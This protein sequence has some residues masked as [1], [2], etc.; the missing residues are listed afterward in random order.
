MNLTYGGWLQNPAPPKGWL[1]PYKQWD[2]YHRPRLVQDF[3]TIHS[4]YG[5]ITTFSEWCI[6]TQ[7][8]VQSYF[9]LPEST[10]QYPTPVTL[11]RKW[12]KALDLGCTI[13]SETHKSAIFI[14]FHEVVVWIGPLESFSK[15]SFERLCSL[16]WHLQCSNFANEPHH[17]CWACCFVRY[18]EDSCHTYYRLKSHFE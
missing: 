12:T 7:A 13:F 11:K 2:V 3:A 16:G 4:S 9:T 6:Y 1:K 5:K 8:I 10:P 17:A 14:Y 15:A 18:S